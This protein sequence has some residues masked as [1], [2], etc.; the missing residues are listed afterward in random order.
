MDMPK[1]SS[2]KSID[3]ATGK[4]LKARQAAMG[5]DRDDTYSDTEF[6]NL[7]GFFGKSQVGK[8]NN[9]L[10]GRGGPR[11]ADAVQVANIL[12]PELYDKLKWP[13]PKCY[14]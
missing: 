10:N 4:W 2:D 11:N 3:I 6:A 13:R 12:G 9:W 5:K 8:V 7:L 1:P 14:E